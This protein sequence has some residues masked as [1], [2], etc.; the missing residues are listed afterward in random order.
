MN[1]RANGTSFSNQFQTI[2]G[3]GAGNKVIFVA[4]TRCPGVVL[5]LI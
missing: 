4:I 3:N 5:L 1:Y 2:F